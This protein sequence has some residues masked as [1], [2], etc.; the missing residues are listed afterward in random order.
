IH[1]SDNGGIALKVLE[2]GDELRHQ[3]HSVVLKENVPKGHKFALADIKQRENIMKYGYPIG[4]ATTAISAG[5]WVHTHNIKTNLS[6]KLDYEYEPSFPDNPYE[7][8]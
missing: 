2:Q 4:H 6:G 7:K 1:P 8:T 5:E 3:G